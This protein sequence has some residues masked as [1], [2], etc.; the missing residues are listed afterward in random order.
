MAS[1]QQHLMEALRQLREYGLLLVQDARLPCATSIVA[2]GP[3]RGSWLGSPLAHATYD[4]LVALEEHPDVL[5]TKLVSGKVTMVHRELWPAVLAVAMA[6]APWQLEGLSPLARWLL[7]DVDNQGSLRT[8]IAAPPVGMSK[9]QIPE[10]ARELERHLLVHSSEVH[11]PSGAHAKVL[12]TWQSWLAETGLE[13]ELPAEPTGRTRLEG[14][15]ERINRECEASA[16][17]PWQV[18]RSARGHHEVVRTTERAVSVI[19]QVD[20]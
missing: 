14:V 2:G 6:R 13:I 8:D 17:L 3:M 15:L 20:Q 16:R 5:Q 10:A 4:L 19:G 9:R 11:T 12:E 18:R 7:D 1:R